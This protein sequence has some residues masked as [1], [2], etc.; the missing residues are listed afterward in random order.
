MKNHIR[1]LEIFN[2]KSIKHLKMECRRIN[3]FVGRPNVGKSNILEA[4]AMLGSFGRRVESDSGIRLESIT[5]LFFDQDIQNSVGV[6]TDQRAAG[7]V[8][9]ATEEG[10]EFA[11]IKTSGAKSNTL[12]EI[13]QS[14]GPVTEKEREVLQE[15]ALNKESDLHAYYTYKENSTGSAIQE[16]RSPFLFFKF[17]PTAKTIKSSLLQLM[18]PYGENLF[19]VLEMNKPLR[20]EVTELFGN[21]GLE[22][23]LDTQSR[24][25]EIIKRVDGLIYKIPYALSA[26]TLQRFIFHI[27]A[28]ESNSD[29]VI[30]FEEPEAH[31]FPPYIKNIAER[32]AG[33][34]TNQFFVATHS[35]YLFNNLIAE[36]PNEQLA[37]YIVDMEDFQTKVRLLT[38]AEVTELMEYGVDVFFN[39]RWFSDD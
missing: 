26:D 28:I 10:D 16:N 37:I 9:N 7:I 17:F 4:L 18:P 2:F 19:K 1:N 21:Y 31:S 6:F 25:F 12:S 34:E 36:V 3:V 30:L 13:V 29:S 22:F 8:Y 11:L 24:Q 32:I 35:P 27:A 38:D 15:W 5:N 23:A 39:L 33:S 14:P 20:Q